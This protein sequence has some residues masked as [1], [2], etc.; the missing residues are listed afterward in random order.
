MKT[1][2]K[3]GTLKAKKEKLNKRKNIEDENNVSSVTKR[4]FIL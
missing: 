3:L 2:C 1:N 4:A